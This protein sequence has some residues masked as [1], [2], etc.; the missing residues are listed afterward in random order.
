[1]SARN[2]N[3][4]LRQHIA[5]EAAR[6]MMEGSAADHGPAL[7]KA[8]HR[9]GA[10]NNRLWPSNAEVEEALQRE[11]RLFREEQPEQLRLL[12]E[13]A[14]QAMRAF[15]RFHPHLVGPVLDG[16]ADRAA[17][18]SLQLFADAPEEVVLTLLEQ[19]IPWKDRERVLRYADGGRITHPIFSFVAGE[20]PIELIVLPP[21]D[22][23]APPLSPLTDK[24]ERGANIVAVQDLLITANK[25][26]CL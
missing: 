21:G 18:I 5:Y 12:R 4:H 17:R 3:P 16:T 9:L 1:M 19:G 10:H 6:L 25:K 13:R 24:P 11:L 14:L 15:A 23:Q 8:A 22:R 7:R 26:A 2:A 20:I